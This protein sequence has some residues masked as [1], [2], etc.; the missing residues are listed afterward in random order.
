VCLVCGSALP[1]WRLLNCASLSPISLSL[2]SGSLPTSSC[3]VISID[4]INVQIKFK[5][6]VNNVK[7]NV[8]KTFV[9]V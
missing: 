2:L 4:V 5:K 8:G 1:S 9:N 6:N 7:E 3:N